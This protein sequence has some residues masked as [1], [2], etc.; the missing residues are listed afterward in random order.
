MDEM[1]TERFLTEG[2]IP[3]DDIT[4]AKFLKIMAFDDETGDILRSWNIEINPQNITKALMHLDLGHH[5]IQVLGY[6]RNGEITLDDNKMLSSGMVDSFKSLQRLGL[7][8]SKV[9]GNSTTFS[10][11]SQGKKVLR[12]L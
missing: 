3:T 1:K 6:F 4:K 2:G 8:D 11:T 9:S 5:D 12:D 10:L 7:V